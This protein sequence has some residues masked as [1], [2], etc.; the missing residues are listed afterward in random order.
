MK[1]LPKV[2]KTAAQDSNPGALSRESDLYPCA[3]A[4]YVARH[5]QSSSSPSP[6]CPVGPFRVTFSDIVSRVTSFV[7]VG[8]TQ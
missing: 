4:L 5:N 3:I 6:C 7:V 2:F 1:N 8:R